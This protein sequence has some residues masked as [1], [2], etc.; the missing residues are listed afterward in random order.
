MKESNGFG[1]SASVKQLR[2]GLEKSGYKN[3][4]EEFKKNRKTNAGF[5]LTESEV[6]D[7]GYKLIKQSKI[8][9]A[10]QIFKLNVYLY[11][12]SA[13]VYDS[14]G[15]TYA[16]LGDNEAAITNYEQSLKLNPQNSNAAQQLKKLKAGK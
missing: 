15:E 5:T 12:A 6:N 8:A 10:L 9:D 3:A 16:E 1:L 7:W 4:I 2:A 11:P 14:L 13:N